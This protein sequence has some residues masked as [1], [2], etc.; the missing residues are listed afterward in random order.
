[1][2]VPSQNCLTTERCIV[3]KSIIFR[4]EANQAA[5]FLAFGNE[6]I[7]TFMFALEAPFTAAQ[8]LICA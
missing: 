2:L 4:A 8:R 1:M 7:V 6:A 5:F 3:A